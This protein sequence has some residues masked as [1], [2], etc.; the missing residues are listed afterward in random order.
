MPLLQP[1]VRTEREFLV[2]SALTLALYALCVRV[3]SEGSAVGDRLKAA[4]LTFFAAYPLFRAGVKA[5]SYSFQKYDYGPFTRELH[6]T[7]DELR[8][9][10]FLD[11][12]SG[13]GQ[14]VLTDAGKDVADSFLHEVLALPENRMVI[15]ALV[16]TAVAHARH[17]TWQVIRDCYAM[18]VIPVGGKE[19]MTVAD[20]PEG[21]LLTKRLKESARR[22]QL[23]ASDSWLMQL[24][25]DRRSNQAQ[26]TPQEELVRLHTPELV[27]RVAAALE[28]RDR[29]EGLRM[30]RDDLFAELD[31]AGSG[32]S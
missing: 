20:V 28:R 1:L 8:W 5:F 22:S 2:D 31:F 27:G 17:P 26:G 29:G 7:W 6:E 4:K 14:L 21:A 15:T 3:S 9:S 23:T 19:A 11:V 10:G 32:S 13:S 16:D 25:I 30:S 12:P 18:T 24:D